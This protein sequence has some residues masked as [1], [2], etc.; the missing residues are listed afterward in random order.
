MTNTPPPPNVSWSLDLRGTSL[1]VFLQKSAAADVIWHSQW[2]YFCLRLRWSGLGPKQKTADAPAMGGQLR[3]LWN[4]DAPSGALWPRLKADGESWPAS[5]WRRGSLDNETL[6]ALPASMLASGSW[7][8]LKR[9]F[10]SVPS[11]TETVRGLIVTDWASP[12][13]FLVLL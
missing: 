8:H 1:P 13:L 2:N 6:P 5:V 3:D 9:P 4:V 11:I 7:M 12:Q 10:K